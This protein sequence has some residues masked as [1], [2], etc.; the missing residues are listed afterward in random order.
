[1][2]QACGNAL[3]S[4]WLLRGRLI[5]IGLYLGICVALQPS[6]G[7]LSVRLD[8]LA[9]AALTIVF[10]GLA[11]AM[12]PR[13]AH[14]TLLLGLLFVLAFGVG[15]TQFGTAL[16]WIFSCWTVGILTIRGLRRSLSLWPSNLTEAVLIGS[17]ISF[18]VWGVLIHFPI[19]YQGLHTALLM[20]PLVFLTGR[21][22]EVRDRAVASYLHVV[23]PW[24]HALPFW[25]WTLGLAAISWVLRWAS[26]P[27]LGF[28]DHANHLRMWTELSANH[29]Y[30]FDI[31]SQIWSVAPFLVN[32]LHAELSLIAGDDA[33]SA[34]NLVLASVLLILMAGILHR[35]K[36]PE[37]AQW[38]L[39]VLMASTPM[40]GNLLL[41]LQ[42]ELFLAV[43]ALAGLNLVS[44]RDGW[45][46]WYIYG[47]LACVA[48]CAGTKLPGAVLG[49]AILVAYAIRWW[50]LRATKTPP[51]YA[52]RITGALLL[53]PL[54]FVALH[55]Y[56]VAWA[57]TGNPV[58]P[59]YNAVFRAPE[60]DPI[61]FSDPRWIRGFSLESY[62]RAFFHTSEFLES[63]NFVAGWQ[64]LAILPLAV[65]ALMRSGAPFALRVISV[66]LFGF[67]LVMF[68]ATQYWR[69][70]FPVMP[71]AGVLFGALFVKDRRYLSFAVSVLALVCIGANLFYFSSVTWIMNSPASLAFSA[72]GQRALKALYAPAAV[73]T[74]KVNELAPGSRVLYHPSTPYGATLHG[75]PLYPNWYQPRNDRAFQSVSDYQTLKAYLEGERPD[76]AILSISPSSNARE[77]ILREYMAQFG[78][79]EGQANNFLLYRL[80]NHAVDYQRIFELRPPNGESL[81]KAEWLIPIT[82]GGI[83]ASSNSKAVANVYTFRA[84]Q[85]RYSIEFKCTSDAG[86]FVAQINWDRGAPYYRLIPCE[87][88]DVQFNEAIPIPVGANKGLIYATARETNEIHVKNIKVE[89]Y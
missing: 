85:A 4:I 78:Y 63:G 42:T 79:L 14:E 60:F 72:D 2:M 45:R 46:S 76:F 27:S 64:Y 13:Q 7:Q 65:L 34:L 70:L 53:I 54:G 44:D 49:M 32:L 61:N 38:L 52:L 11:R 12:F 3:G 30:S 1:M 48:M 73:L 39:I 69:Y 86:F 37:W 47:V 23:R 10:G 41:S 77:K 16:L 5:V 68:S 35:S 21:F 36:L 66:P 80:S 6:L 67:G 51:E 31:G 89:I 17:A 62:L 9:W 81:P 15:F 24:I 84:R 87:A 74:Q 19:N 56:G 29:R 43:L 40:L 18:A 83:T 59:L 75:R 20:L 58:F 25:S 33:R 26:L 57:V 55:S 50:H 28:D 22:T 82:D 8:A 88:K 71:L